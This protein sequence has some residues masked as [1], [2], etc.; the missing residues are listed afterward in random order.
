MSEIRKCTECGYLQLKK[1]DSAE[2]VTADR[3]YRDNGTIPSKNKTYV[4]DTSPVCFRG[5]PIEDECKANDRLSGHSIASRDRPCNKFDLWRPELTAE[6]HSK[7]EQ[8][9]LTAEIARKR[10]NDTVEIAREN[11]RI[12]SER[13]KIAAL[14]ILVSALV[15]IAIAVISNRSANDRPAVAPIPVL[16]APVQDSERPSAAPPPTDNPPPSSAP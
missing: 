1:R 4:Y 16:S 2:R 12:S 5:I 15:A 14:G 6:E 8:N 3:D 7:L 13:N 11:A 10:H 9:E